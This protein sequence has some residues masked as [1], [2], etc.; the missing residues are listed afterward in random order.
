[1]GRAMIQMCQEHNIQ[2]TL[3]LPLMQVPVDSE[4]IDL[5]DMLEVL[6]AGM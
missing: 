5:Y 2:V 4:D 1:M 6:R 3:L